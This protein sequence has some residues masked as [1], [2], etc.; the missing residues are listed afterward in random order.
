MERHHRRGRL[1]MGIQMAL[2]GYVVASVPTRIAAKFVSVDRNAVT[3][4]ETE[5][6][7][8]V[9]NKSAE[10]TVCLGGAIDTSESNFSDY[11]EGNR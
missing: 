9:A 3:L 2:I 1:S 11:R 7:E 10:V 6:A 5:M 8:T 4:L